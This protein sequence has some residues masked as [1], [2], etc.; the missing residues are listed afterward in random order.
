M[1]ERILLQEVY[2]GTG[3]WEIKE[4]IELTP[5]EAKFL[6]EAEGQP[7]PP[8]AKKMIVKGP[9]AVI[10]DPTANKRRYGKKLWERTVQEVAPLIQQRSLFG[11]LDHPADGQTLLQRAS[12]YTTA[13]EIKGNE[14]YGECVIMPTSRGRDLM[15][16]YESGGNPGVS[17]RGFGSLQEL[18]DGTFRVNESDFGF[19]AFD[20]V[21]DPAYR[22]AHPK[23]YFEGVPLRSEPVILE[24]TVQ[25]SLPS[26][27]SRPLSNTLAEEL[28]S[29]F[30]LQVR[31]EVEKL[32]S[33]TEQRVRAE[34]LADPSVAGSRT[35]LQQV[36]ALLAP[37]QVNESTIF[38]QK[39]AEIAELRQKI[40]QLEDSQRELEE[41]CD[42]L[43]EAA[44]LATFSYFL[45][46][47]IGQDPDRQFIE[48]ILGDLTQYGSLAAL[49]EKLAS[50]QEDVAR[51]RQEEQA[52]AEERA[53]QERLEMTR[54][55]QERRLQAQEAE[56]R[57]QQLN[58]L[59]AALDLSQQS[60]NELMEANRQLAEQV[61][62]ERTIAEHPQGAQLRRVM[63]AK[64][65]E[66]IAEA[67]GSRQPTRESMATLRS[68]AAHLSRAGRTYTPNDEERGN[69]RALPV[70]P[71]LGAST[72]EIE[73]LAGVRSPR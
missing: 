34:L 36:L 3:R 26:T 32:R 58:R 2:S 33:V 15:G 51:K 47:N 57:D 38:Q 69:P 28:R 7:L 12:H 56:E 61:Q 72:S 63:N 39:D 18:E 55:E 53:R 5:Q 71:G 44:Q 20:F 13:L 37:Y 66:Q 70:Q 46:K 50:I 30:S 73:Y 40:A 11:E 52:R 67:I 21:A 10:E 43:A 8:H 62:A 4:R 35:T 65:P 31:N 60:N 48:R 23:A 64:T 42:T 17:T 6:S 29:S 45:E 1:A 19:Q 14:I 9:V 27:T 59:H 68:K 25:T 54:R 41:E 22:G 49:Q 16:I 24:S